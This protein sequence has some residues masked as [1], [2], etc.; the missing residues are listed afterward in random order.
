MKNQPRLCSVAEREGRGGCV[1]MPTT[2]RCA[3]FFLFFFFPPVQTRR[4]HTNQCFAL[5]S[6]AC[7]CWNGSLH[8]FSKNKQT[9]LNVML[10]VWT[11]RRSLRL[12]AATCLDSSRR[13]QQ[14][15]TGAERLQQQQLPPWCLVAGGLFCVYSV[16]FLVFFAASLR[17]MQSSR[18]GNRYDRLGCSCLNVFVRQL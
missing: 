3:V 11:R 12:C 16:V 4:S 15:Q 13:L 6:R 10:V 5:R 8:A 17:A 9:P 18:A 1:A 2:A 7:L 14:T